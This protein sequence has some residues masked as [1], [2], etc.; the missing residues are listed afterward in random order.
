MPF[1]CTTQRGLTQSPQFAP[2]N[3]EDDFRSPFNCQ[4]NQS[5]EKK[6]TAGG[7]AAR[8]YEIVGVRD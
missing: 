5:F 7:C 8:D 2:S 6:V 3:I 1:F 4:F